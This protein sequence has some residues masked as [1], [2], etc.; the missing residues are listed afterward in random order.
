MRLLENRVAVVTGAT[1]G[2]G[3]AIART[4]ASHGVSLVVADTNL[5]AVLAV[6]AH[7]EAQ[8]VHEHPLLPQERR[9]TDE[10]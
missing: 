8:G 9:A 10:C 1:R 6:K 7:V 4:F 5:R 3:L 2:I